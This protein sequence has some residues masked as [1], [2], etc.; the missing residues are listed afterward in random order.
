MIYQEPNHIYLLP[1]TFLNLRYNF[2]LWC[3]L[4]V[5]VGRMWFSVCEDATV[6]YHY[7][8]I[9]AVSQSIMTDPSNMMWFKHRVVI[10]FI[11][12]ENVKFVDIYK[13]LLVVYRNETLNINSVHRWTLRVKGFE[14][15]KVVIANQDR[16]GRLLTVT[17]E[18]H[19]QKVKN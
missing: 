17:D 1:H 18:T 15:E 2:P 19:K 13:R 12:A 3:N 7:F 11:I 4:I 10:E 14:V 8:I 16:S 9:Y 6:S 5:Y